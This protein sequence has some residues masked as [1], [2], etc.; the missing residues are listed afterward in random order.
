MYI[1]KDMRLRVYARA[2]P[3]GRLTREQIDMFRQEV[4]GKGLSLILILD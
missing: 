3:E 1:G 4:D 2:W